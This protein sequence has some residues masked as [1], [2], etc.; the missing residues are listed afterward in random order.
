M[1]LTT[2]VT[3]LLCLRAHG[4]GW[5]ELEAERRK[6]S[7]LQQELRARVDELHEQLTTVQK[8]YQATLDENFALKWELQELRAQS[9]AKAQ[10]PRPPSPAAP[11][12]SAESPPR[13]QGQP[14]DD[15]Q[16]PTVRCT[17]YN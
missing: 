1:P 8:A 15:R 6:S 11:T 4:G 7:Q 5:Q 12:R 13:Q 2:R 10:P 9:G 17:A 14:Q 16:P 3:L